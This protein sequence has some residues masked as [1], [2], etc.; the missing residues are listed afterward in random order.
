MVAVTSVAAAVRDAVFG[1]GRDRFWRA[2]DF[3]ASRR[4][5]E[6]EL[7]RLS[8]AG[9]L[10]RVYQGVYWRGRVTVR[11]MT[12]PDRV[13]VGLV[14]AGP[15][16]GPAGADAARMCGIAIPAGV[17]TVVAAPGRAPMPGFELV[18]RSRPVLRRE[19]GVSPLEVAVLEMF[20]DAATVAA[21]GGPDAVLA[22]TELV[23]ADPA[24]DVGRLAAAAAVERRGVRAALACA[25]VRVG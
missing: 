8:I 5:V 6:S 4:A 14:V 13:T 1:G 23:L 12:T 17:P 9:E 18:F 3:S 2:S 21:A 16:S 20:R 7:S 25:G 10:R 15:G 24:V 11:G 22:A 19:L